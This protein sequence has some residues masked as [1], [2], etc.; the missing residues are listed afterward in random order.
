M[1]WLLFV[2]WLASRWGMI[3]LTAA[4][5]ISGGVVSPQQST[6]MSTSTEAGKH[7]CL[8]LHYQSVF[9]GQN[10]GQWNRYEIIFTEE[11]SIFMVC[12]FQIFCLLFYLVVGDK[13]PALTEAFASN[14][15]F[16]PTSSLNYCF[17]TLL[18]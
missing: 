5:S 11:F 9:Y 6:Q 4:G 1:T 3:L 18:F 17:P 14:C 15:S 2:F 13:L 8:P 7:Q 16:S 10:T 12:S